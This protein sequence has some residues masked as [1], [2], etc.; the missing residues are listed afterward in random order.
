M[1]SSAHSV[2]AR[3]VVRLVDV[4]RVVGDELGDGVCDPVEQVV[5][6]LLG[7]DVMEDLGEPSVRLDERRNSADVRRSFSVGKN[8]SGNSSPC[9]HTRDIGRPGA[10]SKREMHPNE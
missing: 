6:V 4:Q 2:R 1:T 3:D 9:A 5:E 8:G 10:G 7:E